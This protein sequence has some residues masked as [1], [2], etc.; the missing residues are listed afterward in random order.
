MRRKRDV[1]VAGGTQTHHVPYV[2]MSD[3][4]PHALTIPPTSNFGN[5]T[6][7]HSRLLNLAVLSLAKSCMR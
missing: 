5:T 2:R 3:S 4:T 6:H 7:S 1:H